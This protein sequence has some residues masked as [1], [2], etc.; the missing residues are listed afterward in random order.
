MRAAVVATALLAAVLALALALPVSSRAEDTLSLRALVAEAKAHNPSLA[1]MKDR[2]EAS[3]ERVPQASALDDPRFF[4]GVRNLPVDSFATD[5]E[6]MTMKE[7]GLSQSLPFF[8]KRGLKG[9]A[10]SR[11][12]S[13]VEGEYADKALMLTA[14]VKKVYFELYS[15]KKGLEIV[16]KNIELVDAMKKIAETRYSVGKGDM[17]DLLKAQVEGSMLLD[18][19]IKLKRDE[20]TKRA[21]LG[22][23]LGRGEPVEGEVEDVSPTEVRLDRSALREV[24]MDSRPAVRSARDRI[25]KGD[26]MVALAKKQFYPDFMVELSYGQRDRLRSGMDQSDMVSAMV[27]MNIP[28]W[29][30]SKL[31]PGLREAASEKSMA[32]SGLDALRTQIYYRI[33]SLIDETEQDDRAL[34]LYKDVVI[35]QATEDMNSALANY[36]VG[37]SDFLT[38]LDSRRTLFDYELGYYTMLAEREKAVA[39]LEAVVGKEL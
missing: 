36:E 18:K 35:P 8:G 14:E 16:D 12:A 28:I 33:D 31:E 9:D 15:I 37:K 23:L 3:M 13:A 2:Y 27:S 5:R 6:P 21:Y 24:A 38:L 7:V 4:V 29:W 34:K 19:K 22:S 30:G 32:E 39:E 10:A 25:E 26:A 17:K 20:G 11:E 1:A